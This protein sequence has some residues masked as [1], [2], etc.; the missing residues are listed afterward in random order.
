MRT[1]HNSTYDAW[2]T[3]KN[4][5]GGTENHYLFAGEQIDK[6]S[7]FYYLR[8]RLYE[9]S[10]GRFIRRD[11]AS[12]EIAEPLTLQKYLYANDNPINMLDPSGFQTMNEL[13]ATLDILGQL[14]ARVLT[15]ALNP[16]TI[17][18]AKAW[19]IIIPATIGALTFV[20][21]QVRQDGQTRL[22]VLPDEE[23]D[24]RRRRRE[25]SS[26]GNDERNMNQMRVQL[27][28][29]PGHTFGMPI[30]NIPELGVTVG[31]VGQAVLALWQYRRSLASWFPESHDTALIKGM[32]GVTKKAKDSYPFDV[33]QGSSQ[34]YSRQ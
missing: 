29:T 33:F 18:T 30:V 8:D 4:T 19:A 15:F 17:E 13:L 22:R 32:A 9:S 27:Q 12:G 23:V 7:G 31:Q 26:P 21:Q 28:D 34:V 2:G 3:L 10:T 16:V 25:P 11:T 1:H 14:G 20:E 24:Y 6:M 5:T